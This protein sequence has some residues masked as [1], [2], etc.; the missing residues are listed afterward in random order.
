MSN[1]VLHE[2]ILH[3]TSDSLI[4]ISDLARGEAGPHGV[5]VAPQVAAR[6]VRYAGDSD[7]DDDYN[8]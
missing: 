4:I 5:P 7:G 2:M 1:I 3:I 8:L 6:H